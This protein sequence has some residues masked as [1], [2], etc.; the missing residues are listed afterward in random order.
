VARSSS[1]VASS[2]S[3]P[4]TVTVVVGG[5]GAVTTDKARW[6]YK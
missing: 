6:V 3:M 1:E 5:V 4:K 2:S